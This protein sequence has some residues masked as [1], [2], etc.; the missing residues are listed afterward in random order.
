[1]T[2]TLLA[3]AGC[4]TSIPRYHWSSDGDALRE[5]SRRADEVKTIEAAC[6]IALRDENDQ[7]V[8][9]DGAL[10]ARQPDHLRIRAWK[11]EQVLFDVTSTPDGVWIDMPDH[12][13]RLQHSELGDNISRAWALFSGEF[14]M[15]NLTID[16]QRS[17][18]GE[19][20]VVEAPPATTDPITSCV[21]E[22]DTLTPTRYEVRAHD[23]ILLYAIRL[24]N[25]RQIGAI[26]W[27]CRIAFESGANSMSINLRDVELNGEVNPNAFTPPPGAVR[28]P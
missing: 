26:I 28:Q 8:T 19:V 1:L 21:V 17:S 15:R 14:M 4:A 13:K 2:F 27:P 24:E 22:R 10:V 11:F 20:I 3:G 25:Y 12:D 18:S 5:L 16:H 9:L 7:H 23:G 6:A